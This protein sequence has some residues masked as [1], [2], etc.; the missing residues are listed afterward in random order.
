MK[1]KELRKNQL[2]AIIKSIDNDFSS[3]IHYHATGSGKSWI[4][5]Y[6]LHQFNKKYPKSN[7][8]WICER[9]DILNHQFDKDT[10][11]DRG[12]KDII[13]KYN[14]LNF[15]ENKNNEWYDSLNSSKFWGKPYLCIMNRCFLTSQKKYEKI[16]NPIHL[17][18]HDECH[19]IENKTTQEFY[20]WLSNINNTKFN[21]QTRVIGF[22]ATPEK[23]K[24]LNKIISKYSIYDAFLDNV[25]LPPKIVWVK[26]EKIPSLLH[27]MTLIKSKINKL[28]YK[29]IIV[30][31]GI[32]EECIRTAD[33][34]SSYFEDFMICLDFNNL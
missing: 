23:I 30:W 1:Y 29:K 6:I 19:S 2:K 24:P 16:K 13:N 22:S 5:I 15:V 34:W 11:R 12:F 21:I 27:L 7:V 28:P 8:L 31:T 4:A 17:V 9:K 10:L 32:I 26:S 3:G 14:I 33:I 20:N 25:I 18:I